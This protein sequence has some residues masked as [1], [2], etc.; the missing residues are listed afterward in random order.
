MS[1]RVNE[2]PNSHRM[3][4][5]GGPVEVILSPRPNQAVGCSEK[6]DNVPNFPDYIQF[7]GEQ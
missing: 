1:L 2:C 7:V 3:T 6:I 4:E 5:G